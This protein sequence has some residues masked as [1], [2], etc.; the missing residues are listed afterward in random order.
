MKTMLV[1]AVVL[2]VMMTALVLITVWP[3]LVLAV[4]HVRDHVLVALCLI[5]FMLGVREVS[6]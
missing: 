2:A 6:R 5:V 1:A 4:G 3:G